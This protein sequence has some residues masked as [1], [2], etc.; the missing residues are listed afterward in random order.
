MIDKKTNKKGGKRL[1]SGRL[2]L[3]AEPTTQ[4]GFK[5]PKSAANDVREAVSKVLEPL[6][7]KRPKIK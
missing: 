6:K 4:I 3:Y 5:V 1:N 7:I 2:P